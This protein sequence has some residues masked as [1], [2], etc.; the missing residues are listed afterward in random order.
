MPYRFP[1]AGTKVKLHNRRSPENWLRSYYRP[2]APFFFQSGT[3]AL[4]AALCAL[5]RLRPGRRS[6]LI[7]GYTCPSLVSAVRFAGCRAVPVDLEPERPFLD[8]ESLAR[9]LDGSTLA[10]VGVDL[11]GIPERYHGIAALTRA[12]GTFLVED[13]AQ[14][15]VVPSYS[16]S[17]DIVIL[18]YGRGKPVSVL[19]GGALL[20]R[21][22]ALVRPVAGVLERL[23]RAERGGRVRRYGRALAYNLL[24]HPSLYWMPAG[25][26]FLGLGKTEYRNLARL[27]PMSRPALGWLPANLPGTAGER[28][29]AQQKLIRAARGWSPSVQDVAANCGAAGEPLSRMPLLADS[30]DL[31]RR[32]VTRLRR[33]G[34]S[35]MYPGPITAIPGAFPANAAAVSRQLP[36]ATQ[37]ASRLFTLPLHEWVDARSVAAIDAAMEKELAP[38]AVEVIE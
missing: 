23:G 18:S 7:P 9:Q 27:E 21:S 38:R 11:F 28:S 25:M 22:K 35:A 5:S 19:E 31:K 2:Y 16:E 37:W 1:P 29:P 34:A 6:V 8:L 13:A 15:K 10:V 24:R 3:Q 26:P 33:F 36:N 17:V 12:N 14:R 32:L 4:A 30:T 20:V